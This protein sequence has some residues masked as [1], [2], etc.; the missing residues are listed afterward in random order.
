MSTTLK[1]IPYI[2]N[3]SLNSIGITMTLFKRRKITHPK[4]NTTYSKISI[5][6]YT[7]SLVGM[8]SSILECLITWNAIGGGGSMYKTV[9]EAA[10][11]VTLL[12]PYVNCIT[13]IYEWKAIKTLL[14]EQK[15]ACME[16]QM[17]KMQDKEYKD[18]FKNFEKNNRRVYFK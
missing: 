6:M 7:S 9:R 5:W 12:V 2:S 16:E 1:D 4:V 10:M 8:S 17:K 18:N 15:G 14:R 11:L 3:L 13:Q